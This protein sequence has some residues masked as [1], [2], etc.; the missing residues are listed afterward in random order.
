MIIRI[1]FHL[2]KGYLFEEYAETKD[3]DKYIMAVVRDALKKGAESVS[4][5]RSSISEIKSS[6]YDDGEDHGRQAGY[7]E[8]IE[9]LSS[10]NEE[11]R[12]DYIIKELE[13]NEPAAEADLSDQDQALQE[14][15]ATLLKDH[16][17]L[18]D[19]HRRH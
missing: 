15:H 8:V 1:S 16:I 13:Q 10:M 7:I 4:I 2:P 12:G 3:E 6:A 14:L 5:S 18:A 19:K 9:E 17:L 11:E